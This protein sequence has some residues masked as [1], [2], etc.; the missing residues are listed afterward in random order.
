MKGDLPPEEVSPMGRE[1]SMSRGNNPIH[2]SLSTVKVITVRVK[3]NIVAKV[4]K[5]PIESRS[6]GFM[7]VVCEFLGHK[8]FQCMFS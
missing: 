1:A 8:I 4:N 5:T 2:T 3:V 6:D 7:V